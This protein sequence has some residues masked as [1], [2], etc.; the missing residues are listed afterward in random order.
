[1]R[2]RSDTG[3]LEILLIVALVLLFGV[4]T[5]TLVSAGGDAYRNIQDNRE[6]DISLRVALSYLTT[7]LRRFDTEGSFS[8][9]E[10]A[11]GDYLSLRWNGGEGED[12]D[13]YETR[14]YLHDGWLKEETTQR[15]I[16]HDAESATNITRLSGFSCRQ[17]NGVPSALL[18]T[19]TIG[20]GEDAQTRQTV[21][22]L[23]AAG[24]QP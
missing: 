16:P 2:S 5:F 21:V 20:E 19:V 7:Q 13:V 22:A 15:D 6:A 1:M 4:T 18:L 24:R 9:E 10:R 14:I 11:V 3:F 12:E 23:S 8:L 17:I